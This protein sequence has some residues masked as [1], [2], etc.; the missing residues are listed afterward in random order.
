[1]NLSRVLT[2]RLAALAL[3]GAGLWACGSGAAW[4]Q[5]TGAG[6]G[7]K[8]PVPY[9]LRIV[10]GLAG[11]NQYTRQEEPFWSKELARLSGGKFDAEIVPFDRAGVPGGEMLRLLQLGVVPFG[12]TLISSF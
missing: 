7:A 4:A 1:M 12:T 5:A 9:K 3:L 10:G 6:P 8:A 11:L 2:N